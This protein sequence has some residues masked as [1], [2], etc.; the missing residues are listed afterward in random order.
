MKLGKL[1][2]GIATA[3]LL[4][5]SFVGTVDAATYVQKSN[6][7]SQYS[8]ASLRILN[9]SKVQFVKA[10]GNYGW[11]K[12]PSGSETIKSVHGTKWTLKTKYLLPST[13]MAL[14]KSS[15]DL[16]NPQA[17]AFGGKY[18]FVLY[19]PHQFHGKGFVV[20]YN[21]STLDHMSLAKAQDSLLKK[22]A[23]MKVG[24]M[25]DVGHG[26]SLAY[27]K[28]PHSIWMWRDR[29]DMKPTAWS[30]IQ[31]ISMS[32]LKPNRAIKFHMNNRGAM[33]PAGHDLTFDNSG[34]AYWWGISGGHVKIYK[35]KLGSRSIHVRLAKQ[36]LRKQ[37]GTHQQSM[38]YNPHNGRLYLVSD[39]SIQTL[40]ARKLN[41]RGSLRPSDIK[42]T[43]FN[44]HREFESMIFDST[45][46]AMLLSN[47][48]PELLRS[49]TRY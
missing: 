13:H 22:T 7:I 4:S 2:L 45:G 39:D 21:R 26:Q 14:G 18:L 5:T 38:G 44:S 37:T 29:A 48:N 40:P 49:T 24:P 31:R 12:N 32:S 1:S 17:A 42:Y 46:H 47:R 35:G 43:R 20:R 16:T 6:A 11:S 34:N 33:V 3:I 8:G 19:A 27:N 36:L 30:T 25:F 9:N 10:N 28:K 41:G 23:G 15:R